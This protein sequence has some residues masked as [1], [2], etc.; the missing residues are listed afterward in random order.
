MRFFHATERKT[1]TKNL[2]TRIARIATKSAEAKRKETT[3][4][5]SSTEKKR[6][7]FRFARARASGWGSCG[8]VPRCA[9]FPQQCLNFLPLW[10]GHG[11]LR[12]TF[13]PV[14]T[15]RAFSTAAAASLTISL[16]G[17]GPFREPASAA[18]APLPP[19]PAKALVVWCKVRC[20]ALRRK[21]SNAIK[22][23]ALRKMLW[24][25][26]VLMLTI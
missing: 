23:E 8:P 24:Q 11:S 1:S 9:Y 20:G 19:P 13:G 3:E 2:Q 12:P 14:R 7:T 4:A 5:R 21:F 18:G 10:H 15:G 17:A 22:L 16:P 26:L 25:I 6:R